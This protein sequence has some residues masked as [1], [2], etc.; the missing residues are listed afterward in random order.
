[1]YIPSHHTPPPVHQLLDKK[2]PLLLPNHVDPNKMDTSSGGE[3]SGSHSDSSPPGGIV[4]SVVQLC[5]DVMLQ[6]L[7]ARGDG[8]S[9]EWEQQQGK[10]IPQHLVRSI[11][12]ECVLC[13]G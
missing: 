6:C 5:V 4:G 1:M 12:F 3:G 9:Y 10:L 11:D 7:G 13:T 2:M 8:G